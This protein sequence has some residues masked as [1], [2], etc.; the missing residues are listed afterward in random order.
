MSLQGY[1]QRKG[2]II[3][4]AP[5]SNTTEE[6]WKMVYEKD[7]AVIVMLSDL[8]EDG[9]VNDVQWWKKYRV[10]L[11]NADTFGTYKEC[12]DLKKVS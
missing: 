3:A 4:Q 1:K 2:F 12:P 7:V 11:S 6:F 10:E 8:V 9:K 5:M